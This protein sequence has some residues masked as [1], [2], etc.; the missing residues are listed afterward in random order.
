M[1]C[2]MRYK[3]HCTQ[4]AIIDDNH[5]YVHISLL[6]DLFIYTMISQVNIIIISHNI[7]I[8]YTAL[9]NYKN[10]KNV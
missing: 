5:N 6:V 2:I 1:F 7:L 9:I 8:V 10:P 3:S 4:V